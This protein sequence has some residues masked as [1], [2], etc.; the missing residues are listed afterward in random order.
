MEFQKC[1]KRRRTYPQ[2]YS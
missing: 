1:S 2:K